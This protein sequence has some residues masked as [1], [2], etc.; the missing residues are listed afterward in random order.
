MYK[1]IY[2]IHDIITVCVE[3]RNDEII[4]N[5]E[6]QL[7][8]F[9][10]TKQGQSQIYLV[11]IVIRDYDI[12][13]DLSNAEVISDYYYYSDNWLNIP[14]HKICFNLVGDS[15][16]VF[17][18]KLLLPI[19]FLV[20]LA[21]QRKGYSLIHAAGFEINNRAFLLPAFG[22]LG[23]TT[24]VAG[25]LFK[26]GKL[27]G[28]DLCIIGNN[29]IYPYPIDFSVY[30]YHIQIL[31]INNRRIKRLFFINGLLERI[32][33]FFGKFKN[34]LARFTHLVFNYLAVSCLNI[35]PRSIFGET[36]IAK[37]QV[38][39]QV[40]FLKRVTEKADEINI[41]SAE[42]DEIIKTCNKIL[43]HE[44]HNSIQY[45]LIYSSLSD[46]SIG[47]LYNNTEKIIGENL[48]KIKCGFVKIP[49]D[50]SSKTLQREFMKYIKTITRNKK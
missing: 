35:S 43:F 16:N 7:R 34:K 50:I 8:E 23:K 44:W 21:L 32:T 30:P 31:G 26:G 17:C 45:L 27:Y 47:L 49:T 12:A 1:I 24:L 42:P 13:P 33:E 48:Q 29:K 18:D 38:I 36:F 28:D 25:M 10:I 19:N 22:G 37:P 41:V 11:D 6:Y 9:S 15:I 14:E 2:S 4:R 20:H 5:I 39:R 46:F 3:T 40:L